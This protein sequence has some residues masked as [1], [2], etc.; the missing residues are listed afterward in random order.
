MSGAQTIGPITHP[1][2]VANQAMPPGNASK[3]I[4]MVADLTAQTTVS[5]DLTNA[6]RQGLFEFLQSCY[7]DNSA[8]LQ[9]LTLQFSGSNQIVICPPNSQGW[10]P[11]LSINPPIITASSTGGVKVPLYFCNVPMPVGFW[12]T[13]AAGAATPLNLT[14]R[15]VASSAAGASTQLMPANTARRYFGIVA[16]Q[17]ATIWINPLGGVAG[18]NAVDCFALSNGQVYEPPSEGVTASAITYFDAAGS[19]VI[20]AWEG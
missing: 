5:F 8:N 4:P 10:V 2:A 18:A 6:N 16:P 1:I 14:S 3:T 12:S 15:S 7:I 9:S 20:S 17:G 13:I 11:V 19:H